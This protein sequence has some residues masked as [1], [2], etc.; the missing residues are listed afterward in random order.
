MK[1][2]DDQLFK[3]LVA[4]MRKVGKVAETKDQD[5]YLEGIMNRDT[6][7]ADAV[8]KIPNCKICGDLKEL[9]PTSAACTN[10]NAPVT[11]TGVLFP[12]EGDLY[13]VDPVTFMT[14]DS[15]TKMVADYLGTLQT[16]GYRVLLNDYI[17]DDIVLV[18]NKVF[19]VMQEDALKRSIDDGK[20]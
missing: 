1:K 16:R 3:D 2:R 12:K 17:P 11:V 13:R 7:G 18:G 10:A 19:Q 20:L 15:V 5:A 9:P 8:C 6:S 4:D 14:E